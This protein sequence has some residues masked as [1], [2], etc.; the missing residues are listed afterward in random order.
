MIS[1]YFP[2]ALFLLVLIF[3]NRSFY[4]EAS[5][6]LFFF[7]YLLLKIIPLGIGVKIIGYTL[8]ADT[9][10]LRLMLLSL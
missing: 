1:L 2:L 5:Y 6:L 3:L 9:L 10:S 8:G 4:S 7:I